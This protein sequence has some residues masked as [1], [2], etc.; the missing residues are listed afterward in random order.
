MTNHRHRSSLLQAGD[1]PD[2]LLPSSSTSDPHARSAA[3]LRAHRHTH[4]AY[5]HDH[6]QNHHLSD[7]SNDNADPASAS[8]SSSAPGPDSILSD[9][10]LDERASSDATSLD[11]RAQAAAVD[12]A[13]A[14]RADDSA[15]Y[16][17]QIVQTI[18]VIQVVDIS[19]SP[20][21]TQTQYA[22]P[23]TVVLDPA[24][25]ETIS[26]SE[27]APTIAL[28]PSSLIPDPGSL[29]PDPGQLLSDLGIQPSSSST[30]TT[31]STLTT[32]STSSKPSSAAP[33]S[34][35]AGFPT[36][37]DASNGTAWGNMTAAGSA[38]NSTLTVNAFSPPSNISATLSNLRIHSSSTL[39]STSDEASPSTSSLSY[40]LFATPTYNA[41]PAVPTV[42]GSAE[43]TPAAPASGGVAPLTPQQK[44]IVGSVVGSVAGV[45]FL[46]LLVMLVL[47]YKRKR[48]NSPLAGGSGS[49]SL[50]APGGD[51]TNPMAERDGAAASVSA[52]FAAL[53]SKRQSRAAGA[54]VSA[55]PPPA[56]E[57][58][59]YRV[60]GR[61]LPSVLYT[62]GDGYSDPRES[63]MSRFSQSSEPF[64]PGDQQFTL[65]AP[66]RPI[67]GMPIMR[68]GPARTPV[69]EDNPFADPATSP[70]LP[71]HDSPSGRPG[72]N[73]SAR[74]SR[75][76]ESM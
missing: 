43:T 25:G 76:Q 13:L 17:T 27:P 28:D 66:M 35:S 56:G 62:G 14:V 42:L 61:K 41:P 74:G 29:L 26:Q 48:T 7:N 18:S 57:R 63:T 32:T 58:G 60:S 5:T 49:R 16:I 36:L 44:Q 9:S 22:Q 24:S 65:G 67:S 12:A 11:P 20:I 19:G 59:F 55:G 53:T 51:A 72:S 46:A 10:H 73:S 37:S 54:G 75:F 1:S 39:T 50:P 68:S 31:T 3:H 69:T 4:H 47:R 23:N 2:I 64:H 38:S 71:R 52:A 45:A 6:V 21:S 15:P 30:S 8:A 33:I 34:A 40:T 70:P